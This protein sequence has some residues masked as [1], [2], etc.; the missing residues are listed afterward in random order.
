MRVEAESE[1]GGLMSLLKRE[2]WFVYCIVTF[3]TSGLYTFALA[4]DLGL[5]E[6]GAWYTKWYNWVLGVILFIYPAI[7]MFLILQIKLQIEVCKKLNV[8]GSCVYGLPYTWILCLIVPILGWSIFLVM[9][10][11]ITYYPAVMIHKGE[12][13][14][15]IKIK[16]EKV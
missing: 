8:K 4:Y 15:L 16:K 11:H 7:L 13:E 10:L 6:K 1:I 9:L 3:F 2:N 5:Y 14:K 12:G